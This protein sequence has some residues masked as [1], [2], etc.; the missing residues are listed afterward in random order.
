MRPV[1]ALRGDPIDARAID[2]P[3]G[4]ARR[5]RGDPMAHDVGDASSDGNCSADTLKMQSHFSFGARI[6]GGCR[7]FPMP[8][9]TG[10]CIY[11]S[12]PVTLRPPFPLQLHNIFQQ[13]GD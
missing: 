7:S 8:R 13:A 6:H 5:A 1:R 9:S 10:T 11:S 2:L 12:F 4:S 3:W